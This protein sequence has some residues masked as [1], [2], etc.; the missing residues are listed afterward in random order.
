M[1]ALSL[2]LVA[3]SVV[4]VALPTVSSSAGSQTALVQTGLVGVGLD[5]GLAALR[6]TTALLNWDDYQAMRARL[7]RD[8]DVSSIT[9]FLS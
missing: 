8:E 9:D 1:L 2:A 4:Q 6:A 7:E 3:G 5:R